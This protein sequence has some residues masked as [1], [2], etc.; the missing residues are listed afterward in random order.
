MELVSQHSRRGRR[1]TIKSIMVYF[2]GR[3][4]EPNMWFE[5]EDFCD[6]GRG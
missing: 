2:T 4:K 5:V 6:E 1:K 3:D